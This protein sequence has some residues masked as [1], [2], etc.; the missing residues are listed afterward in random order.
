MDEFI[1]GITGL[2][3]G[4]VI[5]LIVCSRVWD[6]AKAAHHRDA[7]NEHGQLTCEICKALVEKGAK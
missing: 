7:Y 2:F 3:L 6:E 5:T 1:C 4:V